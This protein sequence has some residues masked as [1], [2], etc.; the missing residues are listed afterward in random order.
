M[1]TKRSGDKV[2]RDKVA[3][4]KSATAGGVPVG[5]SPL[6]QIGIETLERV[7]KG[8]KGESV[9]ERY[10]DKDSGLVDLVPSLYYWASAYE[11]LP[12]RKSGQRT[13]AL[14]DFWRAEPIM[15]GAVFSM[16]AKLASMGWK[17]SGEEG[18]VEF[19]HEVLSNVSGGWGWTYM[20]E[21]LCQDVFG[22]DV[23]GTLEL[24]Y[25]GPKPVPPVIG[26]F[27]MDANRIRLRDN[28]DAPILYVDE[29]RSKY[30]TLLAEEVIRVVSL[31][32]P[33]EEDKG[34]GWCAVSR[35]AEA[36]FV[37]SYLWQYDQEM[38][39]DMPPNGFI[40]VSGINPRVLEAQLKMYKEQR[41]SR[42][43]LLFP[44]LFWLAS[45]GKIDFDVLSFR[46]L[47]EG[48]D[49]QQITEIYAKVLALAFGVDVAEFWQIEHSGATKAATTVQA[50]KAQGKGPAEVL[51]YIERGMNNK[52]LGDLDVWFEFDEP[53]DE[54]DMMRAERFARV[55]SAVAQLYTALDAEGQSLLPRD[56]AIRIL[57]EE[58]LLDA[59]YLEGEDSEAIGLDSGVIEEKKVSRMVERA[60]T[61]DARLRRLY[62]DGASVIS[63]RVDG[64]WAWQAAKKNA[65]YQVVK[66][67]YKATDVRPLV[68]SAL[69]ARKGKEAA[70]DAAAVDGITL[71][72]SVDDAVTLE[73]DGDAGGLTTDELSSLYDE[74]LAWSKAAGEA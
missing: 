67:D 59:D 36:S 13:N 37:L 52:V 9:Q 5:D 71:K 64:S 2:G 31:P 44:G 39:N 49:R 12:D 65:K 24:V 8:L 21:Q 56:K 28:L 73:G 60:F 45:S 47:P 19:A 61:R 54:A 27:S 20:I 1:A 50:K 34:L 4:V 15:S 63:K 68:A 22:A 32:S 29:A 42:G 6:P 14:R 48:L 16:A 18:Q 70:I 26:M 46:V 53:D 3:R 23:G 38:L 55:S 58:G 57:V 72:V 66:L 40:G 41:A 30:R 69:E 7:E 62:D 74:W 33:A 25:P 17:L 35:A 43:D 51:S 11:K 10:V